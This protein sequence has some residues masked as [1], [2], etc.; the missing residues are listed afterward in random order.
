MSRRRKPR[1]YYQLWNTLCALKEK[2]ELQRKELG[3]APRSKVILQDIQEHNHY[4]IVRGLQNEKNRSK[5]ESVHYI[6][7]YYFELFY[8][9]S[10]EAQTLTFYLNPRRGYNLAHVALS[11]TL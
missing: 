5:E 9:Y 6:Y 3:T 2:E 1:Q 11:R 4:T 7:R 8:D 10:V